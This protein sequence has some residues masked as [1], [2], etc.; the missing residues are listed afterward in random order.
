LQSLW[1]RRQGASLAVPELQELEHD[2]SD[3]RRCQRVT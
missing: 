3:P 1:V 2:P